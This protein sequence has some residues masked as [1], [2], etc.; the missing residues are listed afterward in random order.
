MSDRI[1]CPS[2]KEPVQVGAT[3]CPHCQQAIFAQDP[4][5]NALTGMVL[6]VVAFL[7]LFYLLTAFTNFEADRQME[8][9]NQKYD[10]KF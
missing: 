9:L 8:R 5:A 10:L 2:C 1:P 7:V 4:G 3:M 6:W